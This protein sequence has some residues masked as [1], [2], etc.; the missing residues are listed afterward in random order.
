MPYVPVIGSIAEVKL[1]GNIAAAG[2]NSVN[3]LN[4]F[5]FRLSALGSAVT[6]GAL[7]NAFAT[8]IIVPYATACNVR[9]S[10]I[11]S[12]AR[13]VND[14]TDVEFSTTSPAVGLV[15]TDSL[16][17]DTCV[18]M[19][20]RTALRGKRYRGGKRWAAASEADT[21]G[22]VLTGAGLARWQTLQTA[23]NLPFND[24]NGNTWT[25]SVLSRFLSQLA[26][27]PTT[28]IAND[29]TVVLLNLNIG[30]MRGRKIATVR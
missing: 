1:F 2:G 26:V 23:C 17:T 18:S 27:N 15:A 6:K 29:V 8:N 20:F 19:L 24:A 3:T 9:W 14:A 16:P 10:A 12:T 7:N 21:T 25:P 22:D 11:N 5:H 4:I 13:F 28:V 30:T